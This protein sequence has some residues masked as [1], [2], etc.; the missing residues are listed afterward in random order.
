MGAVIDSRVHN[1]VE[2]L[3][4]ADAWYPA[5]DTDGGIRDG[6]RVAE[7]TDLVDLSAW[8]AGTRL[9]LRKER[10][11]PGAQLRF[12]DSDGHRV[13]GSPGFSPTPQTV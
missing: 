6:A 10:R 13:T 5:I 8:P 7:A 9:V 3:N 12:T 11:H 1:A 4:A 2:V